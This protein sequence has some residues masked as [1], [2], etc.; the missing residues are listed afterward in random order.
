MNSLR[1]FLRVVM[2]S[3]LVSGCAESRVE[4]IQRASCVA[5]GHTFVLEE[6]DYNGL[7]TRSDAL[8]SVIDPSRENKDIIY[9][10]ISVKGAVSADSPFCRADERTGTISINMK[11][12]SASEKRVVVSR[13][14]K[15]RIVIE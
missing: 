7:L 10:A 15:W 4:Y 5:G 3:M 14:E 2:A 13:L 9:E 8:V 12:I 6:K 1:H 11:K